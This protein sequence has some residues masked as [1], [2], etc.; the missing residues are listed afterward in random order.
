MARGWQFLFPTVY[1]DPYAWFVF[2]SLV[3]TFKILE[4]FLFKTVKISFLV[5]FNIGRMYSNRSHY[6]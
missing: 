5:G 1:I 6:I 4:I 3:V 2:K